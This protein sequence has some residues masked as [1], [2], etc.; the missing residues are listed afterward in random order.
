[1][2]RLEDPTRKKRPRSGFRFTGLSSRLSIAFSLLFLSIIVTI[3]LVDVFGIP[4]IG[5]QGSWERQRNQIHTRLALNAD[6]RRAELSQQID[7]IKRDAHIGSITEEVSI[8]IGQL[9]AGYEDAHGAIGETGSW[10]QTRAYVSLT[11]L[12]DQLLF[13]SYVDVFISDSET[14]ITFYSRS[15]LELGRDMSSSPAFEHALEMKS[16]SV[17]EFSLAEESEDVLLSVGDVVMNGDGTPQA[18][19]ILVSNFSNLASPIVHTGSDLRNSGEVILVDDDGVILVPLSHPLSDGSEAEPL[20]TAL[21]TDA[22]RF[23]SQGQ[24]LL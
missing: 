4:W 24:G 1:M 22:V 3:L 16:E 7:E 8:A 5:Y 6:L 23:A 20:S 13:R 17:G 15:G 9:R 14:G 10:K 11:R 18:V 19:I 12:L 2:N 21:D